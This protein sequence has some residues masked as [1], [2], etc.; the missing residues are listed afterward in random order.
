MKILPRLH[1]PI[2]THAF[3]I[4]VIL[5][6]AFASAAPLLAEPAPKEISALSWLAGGWGGTREG[7]VSE[8]HW[9]SAD[10]GGLVGMHK[11]VAAGK[12][13][14]FEFLRIEVDAEMRICYVSMP[15]G[16]PPT[17]FCAIEI[18][19]RRVVFEN[20]AHDFPQR[21]LYWLDAAGKL[22]A[23]IEGRMDGKEAA[24]DWVWSRLPG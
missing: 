13:T 14:S 12:M 20:R 17:S 23:R 2:A 11:D 22:H 3:P 7:V 24:M 5:W 1:S 16:A 6:I 18:G 10:G 19:D 21:I 15:G 4:L 9:T 8:E